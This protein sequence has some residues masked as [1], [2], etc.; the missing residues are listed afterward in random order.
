M[1][2]GFIFISSAILLLLACNSSNNKKSNW[3]AVD[4]LSLNDTIENVKQIFTQANTPGEMASVFKSSGLTYNEELLNSPSKVASYASSYQAAMNL[5]V[6]GVDLTYAQMFGRKQEVLAIIDAIRKLSQQL[7]IPENI[8][9]PAITYSQSG[10][11]DRDSLTYLATEYYAAV[12][13]H[14]T[15]TG[16]SVLATLIVSGGWV[17][18]LYIACASFDRGG[19]PP[20]LEDRIASRKYSLNNLLFLLNNYASDPYIN[21]LMIDIRDLKLIYDHVELYDDKKNLH[22]DSLAHIT[23]TTKVYTNLKT[24]DLNKIVKQIIHT[25]LEITR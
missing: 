19:L 20:V 18:A 4:T 24:E 13:K 21:D 5:G 1:K 10:M 11:P 14:F 15:K 6:Y 22:P 2:P 9:E 12:N 8:L 23:A 16:Q 17:E 25:R 7:G 3:P